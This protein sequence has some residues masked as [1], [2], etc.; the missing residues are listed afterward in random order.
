MLHAVVFIYGSLGR[1]MHH[2]ALNHWLDLSILYSVL[3]RSLIS[4]IIE[5]DQSFGAQNTSWC[6]EISSIY[7]FSANVRLT[8][9]L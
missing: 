4:Y 5:R 8:Q 1:T 3:A 6:H 2:L 9:S 7:H